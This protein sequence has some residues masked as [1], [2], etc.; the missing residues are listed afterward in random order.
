MFGNQAPST[1]SLDASARR[2][3][4]RF[5]AAF[6]RVNAHDYIQFAIKPSDPEAVAGAEADAVRLIGSGPQHDAIRGA[7]EAFVEAAGI[8]YSNHLAL[9]QYL[10][11][12]DAVADRPD[13]R[14]RFLRGLERAVAALVLWDQLGETDRDVLLGPWAGVIDAQAQP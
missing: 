14:Q 1:A 5:A 6:D 2:R 7:I 11:L 13:D 12:N 10:L 8:A 3:L 4:D 9:P